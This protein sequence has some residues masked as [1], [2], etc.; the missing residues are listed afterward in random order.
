MDFTPQFN[1]MRPDGSH[2][3]AALRAFAAGLDAILHAAD[4]FA[5]LGASVADLGTG[6]TYVL[7]KDRAA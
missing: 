4:L 7:M 5:T 6:N 3:A 1:L 2:F